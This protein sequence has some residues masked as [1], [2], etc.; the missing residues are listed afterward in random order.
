MLPAHYGF[1][2]TLA[3]YP[4]PWSFNSGAI[5]D[6]SNQYAAMPSVH[7]AWAT[8]CTLVFAPRVRTMWARVLAVAHALEQE[9]ARDPATARPVPDLATLRALPNASK[10]S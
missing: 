1:V 10:I 8:W 7:V 3:R 5:K 9:L 4:T 6:I 2:D